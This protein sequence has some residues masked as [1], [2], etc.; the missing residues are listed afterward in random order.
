MVSVFAI[1]AHRGDSTPPRWSQCYW[2]CATLVAALVLASSSPATAAAPA[3]CAQDISKH[4]SN[5]PHDSAEL[6]MCLE[7]HASELLP[8]CKKALEERRSSSDVRRSRRNPKVVAWAAPCMED[9]QKL[10][11]GIPAGRG[12]VAECLTQHQAQLSDG[13]KAVFPPKRK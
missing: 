4:C 8:E 3:A 13:C 10:C 9:V 7:M 5:V 11:N 2:G 6:V 12:R 1:A